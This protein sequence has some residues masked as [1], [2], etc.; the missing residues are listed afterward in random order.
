MTLQ[1]S[2]SNSAGLLLSP[3][4]QIV[5]AKLSRL[6]APDVSQRAAALILL[7]QGTTQ[8]ETAEQ[9]GLSIGQIRYLVKRFKEKGMEMFPADVLKK[10]AD[11]EPV[12]LNAAPEK[13][14]ESQK[15]IAPD[16]A[17]A[18]PESTDTS[19]R[20]SQDPSAPKPGKIRKKGSK[21][22]P[23]RPKPIKKK[24]SKRKRRK[25]KQG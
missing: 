24:K 13:A 15:A 5:C 11:S 21:K 1:S 16:G 9:S 20:K 25:K 3:D 18:S 7:D 22:R 23:K 19:A 10:A 17:E 4:H 2:S 12:S 8:A 6:N 14:A